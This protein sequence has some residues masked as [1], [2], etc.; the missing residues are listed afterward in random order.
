[1]VLAGGVAGLTDRHAQGCGVQRHLGNERRSAGGRGLDR[2]AQRLAVTHQLVEITCPTWDLSDRPVADRGAQG[3]DIQLMEEVPEGRIRG[4]PPQLDPE[5]LGEHA[6]VTLGKALQIALALA[7]T[8]DSQ[9]RHQQ[10]VP[11]G[12]AHPAPHAGIGDRPQKADQVEIGCGRKGF[13]HR[14]VAVPPTSTLADSPGQG[15]CDTL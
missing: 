13:G 4:V 9:H 10:Q 2:A 3:G 12:N 15:E 7:V 5:G 14:R 1:M 8:E 11:G 6:V